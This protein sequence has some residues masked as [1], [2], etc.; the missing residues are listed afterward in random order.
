MQA[1]YSVDLVNGKLL[2]VVWLLLAETDSASLPEWIE[3]LTAHP[4]WIVC[5]LMLTFIISVVAFGDTLSGMLSLFGMESP[6]RS[7]HLTLSESDRR[8]IR[9]KLIQIL[10]REIDQRLETSL[11]ERVKLDLYMEDQRQRVGKYMT[12]VV[13]PDKLDAFASGSS[14]FD[15]LFQTFRKRNS[16]TI[17][18][19]STQKIVEIFDQADIQGKLLILGEPGSGKTT[20][21]LHLGKDLIE[22]TSKDESFPIPIIVELSAWGD[23]EPIEQWIAGVIKSG[24][25]K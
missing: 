7:R 9:R 1:L 15:R 2:R 13:P 8:K 18:V 16:R 6:F 12:E 20:E 11:H 4:F 24:P 14:L 3:K 25:K 19:A 22:R 21:I 10:E 17:P 5:S 23:G